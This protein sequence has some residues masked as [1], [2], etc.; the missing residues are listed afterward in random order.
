M[1]HPLYFCLAI[2]QN[3]NNCMNILFEV[4]FKFGWDICFSKLF[5]LKKK[6]LCIVMQSTCNAISINNKSI[7]QFSNS[8]RDS[9]HPNSQP[10]NKKWLETCYDELKLLNGTFSTYKR[11]RIRKRQLQNIKIL[12]GHIEDIQ[13]IHIHNRSM[14]T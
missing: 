2:Y 9:N 8:Q 7:F 6:T 12:H 1:G 13:K 10:K 3:L 4:Y 14:A 5:Q 11:P